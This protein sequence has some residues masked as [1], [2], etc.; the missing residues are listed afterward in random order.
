MIRIATIG[1][2]TI[3]ERFAAAVA[4]AHGEDA[5]DAADATGRG[6]RIDVA[7]SRDA[8]R[9][10]AFA[11][12]IGVSRAVT[13]LDALL[14]SGDIDA[15]YVGSPNGVHSEQARRAIAAGV[16]VFLEKPAT[17]TAE[18]FADLVRLS[19][20]HGVI[21]FEGMRNV[22]DP[23]LRR[24][25]ELLPRVGP[26]RL[27]SLGQSQYSARYD[28]VLRGET[29]NIFDPKLSGGALFDLGV[30]PLSALVHLFGTPAS[31]A[32]RL[33]EIAT[34]ADGAGA[35][36]LGYTDTV[37]QVSFSKIG[38]SHRPNE[39]QGEWGTITF[40][41]VTAPREIALSLRAR[42]DAAAT[43]TAERVEA[44]ANNM[45]YEVQRF[46]ALVRGADPTPDQERTLAVLR[47]VEELRARAWRAARDDRSGPRHPRSAAARP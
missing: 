39:I 32:G 38:V 1:T 27:V 8:E 34:G 43:H 36:V 31:V 25:A 42:G 3:T 18:E 28:L 21:V 16:H 6:I 7:Y 13:D 35:A 10:R 19:R 9:G 14:A 5:G 20:E 17:P 26:V 22:Y 12:R 40:D 30:Y 37:A 11:D 33:V 41:E 45:I 2:S 24:V 15:V 46:A 23:G 47:I 44:A 29:P 4:A